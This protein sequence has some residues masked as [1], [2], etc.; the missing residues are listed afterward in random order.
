MKPMTEMLLRIREKKK[1][2]KEDPDVVDLSGIP[3][4]ATDLY[5]EKQ[6]EATDE[7]NE[8]IPITRSEGNDLS[9]EEE[10]DEEKMMKRKMR[11]AKMIK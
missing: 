4:D 8:N 5:I 3:E 2:M 9:P 7:L 1:K 6:N 10:M 11:I